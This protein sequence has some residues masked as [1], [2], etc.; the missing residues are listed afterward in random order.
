VVRL[1][2]KIDRV[3]LVFDAAKILRAIIVVDYKGQSKAKDSP[4]TLADHIAKAEDCQL[5]AYAL[6]AASRFAPAAPLVTPIYMQYLSY[7]LAADDLIKDCQKRWLATDGQPLE[8]E[9]LE[10][11]LNGAP[12]LMAAFT[13]STFAA[14]D[15]YERGEFAVAPIAC[16]YCAFAGGCRH[17]A[18]LLPDSENEE[19]T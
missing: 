9:P 14:L 13:A 17:Y 18:S 10:E 7:S 3:D 5:P 6:A 8:P 2:G 19:R 15:K 16:E 4:A 11:L 12:T 1:H